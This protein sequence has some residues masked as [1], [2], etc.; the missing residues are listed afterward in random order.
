MIRVTLRDEWVGEAL[1]LLLQTTGISFNNLETLMPSERARA[2]CDSDMFHRAH[3]W[4]LP[5]VLDEV[6]LSSH[7]ANERCAQCRAG[8]NDSSNGPE[9][10]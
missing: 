1:V 4:V 3:M 10:R 7:G 2:M 6:T 8:I 5:A 9:C